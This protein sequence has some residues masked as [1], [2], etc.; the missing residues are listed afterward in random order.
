MVTATL[1][2]TKTVKDP[3]RDPKDIVNLSDDDAMDCRHLFNDKEKPDLGN[4]DMKVVV[5]KSTGQKV[6]VVKD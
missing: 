4:V 3:K 1:V 2:I 6:K 5:D